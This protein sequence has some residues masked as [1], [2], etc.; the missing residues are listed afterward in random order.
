MG[1]GVKGIAIG[2]AALGLS[3]ATASAQ[4]AT[5]IVWWH[6]MEGRLGDKLNE[7]VK[8][9]NASQSDYVVKPA[10]KGTYSENMTAT[11]AAFR[12]GK[13]PA[14]TQVFEVGTAS[15]MNAKGAIYPVHQLMSDMK[16]PFDPASY[17]PA[18]TGYYSTPENQMLSLPFNSS[19][20]V[21]YYN[22]DAFEKAGL[23]PNN[24]PK[25]W[26]EIG[27]AGKK[28][29][30][31]GAAACGFTSTWPSWIQIENFTAR[32]D[33]PFASKQNGFGGPDARLTFNGQKAAVAH[34][35]DLVDWQKSGVFQYGGRADSAS[36]QFFSGKCAMLMGSSASYANVRTNAKNF[37]FGV[38]S[39]PYD[40]KVLEA[41]KNSIIGGASLWVLKGQSDD[42]YKGVAQFFTYLSSPEVQADW[43][44]FSGYLPI[45]QAALK[46]TRDQGFYD[47]N[48]GTDIALKQ[49]TSG[50]PTDNSRGL[51]LGNMIQIRDVIEE[52]LERALN[53][54]KSAQQAMDDAA[55]RGNELLTHFQRSVR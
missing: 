38:T 41:P 48:P 19:T 36:P 39:L 29:V 51:R 42:V 25:T 11:I 49:M 27:E 23:D 30:D 4:A 14:I 8:D 46:L 43:H 53:G 17:L 2:M 12:A 16:Q 18:V 24:P 20:P 9:F 21:V 52:E 55:N 1:K 22:R 40:P 5:D 50:T 6:A 35:Q 15:M 37:Q 26:E 28:I 33:L 10:Y 7:M 45:T 44:Q 31:S 54:Q 32:H 3:I 47:K 34:V 13:G